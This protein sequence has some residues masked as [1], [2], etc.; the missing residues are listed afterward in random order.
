MQVNIK[1]EAKELAITT[2]T[3]QPEDTGNLYGFH[4]LMCGNTIQKIGGKVSKICPFYEPTEQTLSL[5]K[6]LNCK[7]E[8][9]FQTHD[10]YA[11]DEIKVILHPTQNALN[12]FFC[13]RGKD[14]LLEYSATE[15]YSLVDNMT[16]TTPFISSCRSA[17]CTQLYYFAD[18]LQYGIINL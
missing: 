2:I 8:Y 10:G 7:T 15:I 9:N 18:M 16:R 13:Y 6:C 12:K 17:D 5:T 11:T 3:L 4:C 1:G 14:L